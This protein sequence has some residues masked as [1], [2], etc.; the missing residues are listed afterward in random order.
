MFLE[1]FP[2]HDDDILCTVGKLHHLFVCLCIYAEGTGN[3][4]YL[5]YRFVPR[6][7]QQDPLEDE[8][9]NIILQGLGFQQL[10]DVPQLPVATFI[11]FSHHYF[12]VVFDH[13]LGR[14]NIYGRFTTLE[15]HSYQV[16][17]NDPWHRGIMYRNVARL[18]GFQEPSQEPVWEMLNWYQVKV[19]THSV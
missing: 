17:N 5:N 13:D 3:V 7:Q 18:F 2:G 14:I 1:G 12:A 6:M 4:I 11:Y 15:G 9:Q 10:G 19:N 8:E 16:E